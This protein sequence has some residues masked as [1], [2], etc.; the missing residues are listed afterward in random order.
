M[1]V[2]LIGFFLFWSAWSISQDSTSLIQEIQQ[3]QEDQ[4]AHYS[5][6]KTS[7][8]GR[9]ERKAFEGHRFYPIDLSY[10]VTAR[11]ERI[12]KEDT[13][14]MLTSIGQQK[15]YRPYAFVH[16]KINGKPCQLT[17]YQ[18]YVLRETKEYKD[19]LFIPFRDATS[20]KTSYGGGRYLD[21]LIPEGNTIELN[22]NLAYNPYCAYTTGY[23]CTIPPAENTLKVAVKAGL[24]APPAH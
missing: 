1:R 18:S 2:F 19:Y 4:N 6:K 11:F 12:T 17:V 22:F 5:N 8:L 23:N 15:L 13:V 24:M 16:F 21:V 14:V 3:F 10:C 9:K 7:P 20:G